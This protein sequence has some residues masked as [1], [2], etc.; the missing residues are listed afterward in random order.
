MPRKRGQW[1]SERCT[2]CH[3]AEV[4]FINYSLCIGVKAPTLATKYSLRVGAI[5]NHFEKHVAENYKK[6]ISSGVYGSIDELLKSCVKGDAES[7]D[8]LNAMI[9]GH[10]HS[11]SVAFANGSQSGMVA[12]AAQLRAL[13]ELRSRI[14][15]ELAP[16]ATYHNV[17]NNVL[18][19]DTTTLLKILAPYPDARQAIVDYYDQRPA[20]PVTEYHVGSAD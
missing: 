9:S 16:S 15:R 4:G 3:H 13:L 11:W 17:T 7:I 10:F 8:V 5:Y 14:T 20:V 2:V 12:H 18:M 1:Q 6:I 19:A